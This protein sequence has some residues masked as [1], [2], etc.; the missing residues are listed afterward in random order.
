MLINIALPSPEDD[1]PDPG[2]TAFLAA[3][4]AAD[5]PPLWHELAT[6]ALARGWPR[7]ALHESLRESLRIV[8][9]A[10]AAADAA[11]APAGERLTIE[12]A[13]AS[14]KTC[15]GTVVELGERILTVTGRPG[16]VV[17]RAIAAAEAVGATLDLDNDVLAAA[18]EETRAIA[19]GEAEVR[20]R[21]AVARVRRRDPA[22]Y[23]PAD[24]RP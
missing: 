16:S 2:I 23:L 5:C 17:R 21:S 6:A 18:V 1:G 10:A 19:S 9:A 3:V 22:R 15:T 12:P 13:A 4:G 24:D 20:L 11:G 14:Y 8:A 7:D